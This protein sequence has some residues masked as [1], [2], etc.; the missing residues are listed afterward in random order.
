MRKLLKIN[1]LPESFDLTEIDFVD[2]FMDNQN[3]NTISHSPW[4]KPASPVNVDF[5][6]AYTK[7]ELLLKYWVKEKQLKA[8]VLEN[9]GRIWTDSCVEMF[10]NL[11]PEDSFYYNFEFNCL[12]KIL[13]AYRKD[14]ENREF[15]DHSILEGIQ[16]FPSINTEKIESQLGDFE[17]SL[18]VMIPSTVFFKHPDTEFK[19]GMKLRANFYKCGDEM[20]YPHYLSWNM[21]DT[22]KPDFHRPEYFGDILLL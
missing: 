3:R 5:V 21:I 4:G 9:N 1:S 16:C 7:N 17:W 11:N 10:I 8:T 13:F 2:S 20:I 15:S 14:R 12:G 6:L 18:F 19:S 22:A